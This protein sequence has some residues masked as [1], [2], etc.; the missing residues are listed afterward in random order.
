A[1][2]VRPGGPTGPRPF[3][4]VGRIV[5]RQPQLSPGQACTAVLAYEGPRTLEGAVLVVGGQDLVA[6]VE[7]Q[8]AGDGVERR[9]DVG[10]V[11]DL[12]AV[13]AQVLGELRP[14]VSH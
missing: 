1:T 5:E 13:G 12:V 14:R 2:S 6:V 7:R 10:E 4:G 8:R 3:L 11:H 9:G